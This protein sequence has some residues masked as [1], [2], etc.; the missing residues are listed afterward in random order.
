MADAYTGTSALSNVIAAAVDQSIRAEPRP[1][2]LFRSLAD[3]RPVHVDKPGSSVALYT[4]SDLAVAT[5]PLSEL[6]DPD[7]VALPNPTSTTLTPA[8]YGNVSIASLKAKATS[9]ADVDP[10]QRDAIMYNMR[11]TIDTLVRDKISTG[12]N[13]VYGGTRTA[14]NQVTSQDTIS[15]AKVRFIVAKLRG[16]AAQGKRGDLDAS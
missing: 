6:T 7:A 8:E 13:V 1:Q 12:T 15:A 4:H 3:T 2:P 5:T 9:F 14:T 16:N 10:Y 11:D